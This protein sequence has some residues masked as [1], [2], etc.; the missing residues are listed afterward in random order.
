MLP[1]TLWLLHQ[2]QHLEGEVEMLQG[3]NDKQRAAHEGA[4]QEQLVRVA[5]RIALAS[6]TFCENVTPPLCLC[7][8]LP[9]DASPEAGCG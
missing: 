8:W 6:R 9:T 4:I 7:R 3:D 2:V 1:L 5:A